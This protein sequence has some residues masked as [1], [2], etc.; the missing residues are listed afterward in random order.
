[1]GTPPTARG[2]SAGWAT[3]SLLC[4]RDPACQAAYP[5]PAGLIRRLIAKVAANPVRDPKV[6]AAVGDEAA[7]QAILAS[8]GARPDQ[9]QAKPLLDAAAALLDHGDASRLLQLVSQY[10]VWGGGGTDPA[11][12]SNGDN[13]AAI[14][15]DIDTP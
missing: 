3:T 2:R 8:T 13:A 10:P 7:M 1:V 6:N 14:C 5:D 12:F 9:L 15:N 11:T 4:A